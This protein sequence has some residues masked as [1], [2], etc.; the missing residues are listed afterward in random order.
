MSKF[1]HADLIAQYLEDANEC[2]QPWLRWQYR[3]Q[4]VDEET[5]PIDALSESEWIDALGPIPFNPYYEYRRKPQMIRI[6]EFD[7]PE[8][9]R[10]PLKNGQEYWLANV[11]DRT[12]RNCLWLGDGYDY[13][14]LAAGLIHLTEEAAQ[15]HINA[16]LFFTRRGE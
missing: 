15:I 3:R 14:W 12:A 9:V 6:G 13:K 2:E 5:D 10:D 8:P 4:L 1:I 16:L 11:A 7:V